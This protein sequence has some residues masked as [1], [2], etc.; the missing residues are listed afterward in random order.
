MTSVNKLIRDVDPASPLLVLAYVKVVAP[1][2]TGRRTSF[3]SRSVWL[4]RE[5][6][7]GAV[8]SVGQ[9]TH[10]K[11]PLRFQGHRR[12]ISLRYSP[13]PI[14]RRDSVSEDVCCVR[15]RTLPVHCSFVPSFFFKFMVVCQQ[16]TSVPGIYPAFFPVP[17]LNV[18]V[19]LVVPGAITTVDGTA[20]SRDTGR[21]SVP[22]PPPLPFSPCEEITACRE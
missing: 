21:F 5:K 15:L 14:T 16:I 22:P 8:V 4:E 13:P 11:Y 10:S 18:A 3:V 1:S 12:F 20:S 9:W 2:T 6:G 19:S 7:E 17:A